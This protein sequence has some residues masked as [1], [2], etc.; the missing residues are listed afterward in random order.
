MSDCFVI[1]DCRGI[2][3]KYKLHSKIKK[4]FD[5]PEWYGMNWD[6]FNDLIDLSDYNE[7]R[8]INFNALKNVLPDDTA[9]FIEL[10]KKNNRG[11]CKIT[12][13]EY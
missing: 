4:V 13:Y 7:I 5:F 8:F 10:L 12:Y 3:S 9:L 11:N 2:D 1:F 6:A